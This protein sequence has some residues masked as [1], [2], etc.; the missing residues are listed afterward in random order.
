MRSNGAD[1]VNHEN[2]TV[3]GLIFAISSSELQG[4]LVAL[5]EGLSSLSHQIREVR[6]QV[7]SNNIEYTQ[8]ELTQD[9]D[10]K[11]RAIKTL[12]RKIAHLDRC[13]RE[14][15]FVKDHVIQGYTYHLD[16]DELRQLSEPSSF[17]DLDNF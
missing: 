2:K 17:A 14:V 8:H 10:T 13:V 7:I 1:K 15:R 5:D 9:S 16:A 12:D 3:R 4:K 11:K 6:E